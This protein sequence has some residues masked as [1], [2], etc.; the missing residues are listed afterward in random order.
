MPTSFA[1][2]NEAE[3]GDRRGA[4]QGVLNAAKHKSKV[5]FI[6]GNSKRQIISG[7][8]PIFPAYYACDWLVDVHV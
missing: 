3:M 1:L 5:A 6:I 7:E 4:G 8:E 2:A